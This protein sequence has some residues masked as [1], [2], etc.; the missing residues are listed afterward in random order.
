MLNYIVT[1][2][3]GMLESNPQNSSLVVR[4][5]REMSQK[6][7]LILGLAL[8]LIL[9]GIAE[10]FTPSGLLEI[11]YI[12]VG[13]GTSVLVIG[14]DGTTMLMD[15]GRQGQGINHVIPYMESLGLMPSDGLDYILASHLHSDHI[16]GLT[17]VMTHG[18]DVRLEVYYNGSS[19]NT[20]NVTNFRNAASQTTAGPITPLPLGAVIQLGDG[21]TATCACVNGAVL[22]HGSVPGVSDENDRSIGLLIQYGDFDYLFAG[23]LGGGDADNSCTGRNTSQANVETPLAQ[24]IMPGG[25]HPLLSTYGVEVLHVDHHGS[26][27]STNPDYMN[28]LTPR[29]ACIA[30]G[31][32]QSP[33]YM[34]PRHDVVDNVLLSGVYCVSAPAAIVLQ[35]EE[36]YPAGSL[37]SYSGYCVGDI[38]IKTAGVYNYIVDG[39]GAVTEGPD[40]RS[41][42]GMPLTVPFDEPQPDSTSPVVT[43]VA[44]DGGEEW[45]VSSQ[46]DISWSATDEA[47]VASFAIDYSTDNG[48]HWLQI[49]SQTNGNPQSYLWSVPSTPS[50]NCLTRVKAWD[51]A[52]N[53]GSDLSNSVFS[54]IVGSDTLAPFVNVSS[55]NGGENWFEGTTHSITWT[56]GDNVGITSFK[57]EYTTDAGAGWIQIQ[58]WIAGNPGSAGWVVPNTASAQCRVRVSCRDAALNIGMDSSDSYFTI[59]DPLPAVT[60]ISP[61]GGET[62]DCGSSHNLTWSDS[63][64]L[65]VTS[66]KLEY[67]VDSGSNWFLIQ[68]WTGGDPHIVPWAVANTPTTLARVRISCR[69]TSG[70]IGSDVSN[71]NFAIRDNTAPSVIVTAPNGGEIWEAGSEQPITWNA[72]DNVGVTANKIDY[73]IDGGSSWLPVYDWAAGNPGS[74]SWIVPGTLSTQCRVRVQCRDSASLIGADYS[75]ANFTIHDGTPPEVTLSLPNGGESWS[76]ASVHNITWSATDNIIVSSYKIDYST[77]GG[78]G[79]ISV[80][81]WTSGNPGTYPWPIPN[82]PSTL[83]LVRISSRD[84]VEN[85]ASDISDAVFAIDTTSG[86]CEYIVGDINNNGSPNGLDVVFGVNYFKG[87]PQPEVSCDCSPHGN[88]FVAGDVNASCSFNGLDITYFVSFLKGGPSLSPCPDCPPAMILLRPPIVDPNSHQNSH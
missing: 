59:S 55:P 69:D 6:A 58:D 12:N 38:I 36:G 62:W 78:T 88:L 18:Y 5:E 85:I 9:P 34:F 2:G 65:G 17:E 28:L 19:Y 75:D 8:L 44:P 80:I 51:A 72:T 66:F 20:Q 76:V 33:D 57:L 32:G 77:D 79:W 40:E 42:L 54:I 43:V 84:G 47:G 30:T 10:A 22:G 67:S 3:N 46:H 53:M 48:A 60:V 61:N 35:N 45:A 71:A 50:V 81:D 31:S 11:H 74:Y 70:G 14:P 13:W 7:F 4:F 27:S 37:T 26:E 41:L 24:A 16:D 15:G 82:T 68:D 29:F 23:D 56:A 83:C 64:N 86:Q 21:A 49:Q 25:E 63:D 52:G 87:G 73:S 1:E 39:D